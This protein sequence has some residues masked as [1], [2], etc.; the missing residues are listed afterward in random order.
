MA[1]EASVET[2]LPL[3]FWYASNTILLRWPDAA[4]VKS[5]FCHALWPQMAPLLRCHYDKE[6]QAMLPFAY[7]DATA[8][9]LQ[10]KCESCADTALVL[11]FE[12]A[13]V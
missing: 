13:P 5:R 6:F 12:T 7:D 1:A 4:M 11:R 8:I 2:A 9:V 3:R 10:P